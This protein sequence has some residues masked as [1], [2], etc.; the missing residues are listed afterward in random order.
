MSTQ[1]SART[2]N[3]QGTILDVAVAEQV[4]EHLGFSQLPSPT[5]EN[6]HSV[7]K[8]W[9]R[10][11]GYDNVQKRVYFAEGGT[12]PFPLADPNDFMRAF[13]K[14]GTGGS[15][16]VVA[17]A[18]FGLLYHIGYDVRRVAGQMLNCD[19]PMKPNHGTV[20]V[21]LDG[22]DYASDPSMVG[23]EAIPL[24][25]G[26]PSAAQSK[27]H[28]L[29]S[30]GDGNYWWRPGHSRVAIEYMT[31]FDPC[32]YSYFVERYEKTKEFSLF[33][34]VLYVRRNHEGGIRTVGR[35]NLIHIDLEGNMTGEP[36]AEPELSELLVE[37]MGLSEEIVSRLPPDDG[38]ATFGNVS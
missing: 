3:D 4:L 31:Q 6:L 1:S 13:L 20:L 11:V 38:G 36:I 32:S 34:A 25:R 35:G 28:G 17:E 18:Y 24:L 37:Q 14:H 9:S 23:E 22:V 30:T 27:V 19:D 16:W 10:G 26:Q 33:N 15:C 8:A 5:L 7:Y 12:G 29:W 2:E 21:T